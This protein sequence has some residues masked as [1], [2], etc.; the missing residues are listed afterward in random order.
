MI[1]LFKSGFILVILAGGG[2]VEV[3]VVASHPSRPGFNPSRS[4]WHFSRRDLSNHALLS[5]G[6]V[7]RRSRPDFEFQ[8]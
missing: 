1:H 3:S 5:D 4:R 6:E 7:K 8:S 2:G